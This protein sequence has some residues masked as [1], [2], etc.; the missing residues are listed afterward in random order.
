MKA[1]TSARNAAQRA[2]RSI[3]GGAPGVSRRAVCQTPDPHNGPVEVGSSE[4]PFHLLLVG[5]F[6]SK[7]DTEQQGAH[8]P[9]GVG[10]GLAR[11]ECRYGDNPLDAVT[12]HGC[13]NILC[14]A[15]AYPVASPRPATKRG[16]AVVRTLHRVACHIGAGVWRI[17]LRRGR[18]NH[19]FGALQLSAGGMA[20]GYR[21]DDNPREDA[22]LTISSNQL[23][24][25]EL[26]P[27]SSQ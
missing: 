5:N 11:A 26:Y 4:Q 14:R 17:V 10:A 8:Q 9:S 15:G 2:D 23:P 24:L 16:A 20:R 1:A 12:R 3:V 19:R 25:N 6:I 13:G 7:H 21:R 18:I 27:W 22:V